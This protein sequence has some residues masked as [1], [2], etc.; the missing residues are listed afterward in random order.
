MRLRASSPNGCR[1]A[2]YMHGHD[3]PKRFSPRRLTQRGSG[4]GG[5]PHHRRAAERDGVC[6]M[7]PGRSVLRWLEERFGPTTPRIVH[8]GMGF[9]KG[10]QERQGASDIRGRS[11]YSCGFRMKR[12]SATRAGCVTG[13]GAGASVP[14]GRVKSVRRAPGPADVATLVMPSVKQRSLDLFLA[15][16]A[17]TLD[18]DAHDVRRRRLARRARPHRT[19]SPW[20]CCRRDV[21]RVW[22]YTRNRSAPNRGR[23]VANRSQNHAPSAHPTFLHS[24][25]PQ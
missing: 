21:E 20:R 6:A 7:D 2:R 23:A 18:Q 11:A 5:G 12:A 24:L 25:D 15:H 22:L 19:T 13:G 14:P 1:F 3:R 4:A 10:H 17:D 8:G 9:S 16:F